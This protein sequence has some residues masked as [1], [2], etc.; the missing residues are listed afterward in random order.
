MK[1]LNVNIDLLFAKLRFDTVNEQ[2]LDLK[3]DNILK[4]CDEKSIC[5]L[6]A[7][8]N[9]DFIL[10]LIPNKENFKSLLMC[11]KFWAKQRG[12]YSN[13]FGYLGGISRGNSSSKNLSVIPETSAE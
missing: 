4:E 8:R 3:D 5:S 6:N 7:C 10:D 1:Y 13:K 11:I 2:T 9:N 12:L